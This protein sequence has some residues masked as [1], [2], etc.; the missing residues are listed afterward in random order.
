[1]DPEA[2]YIYWSDL[3]DE[4]YIACSW[5]DGSVQDILVD[6]PFGWPNDI[7]L[8]LQQGAVYWCD[9]KMDRIEVSKNMDGMCFYTR[10]G[11][12]ENY[13]LW[14]GGGI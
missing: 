1:M 10:A 5:L 6:L 9:G 3:G 13:V 8:D 7:A 14:R 11:E 12:S 4:P 2:G